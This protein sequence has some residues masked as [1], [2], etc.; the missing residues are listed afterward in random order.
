MYDKKIINE[1]NRLNFEDFLWI[2][3]IAIG[4]ITIYGN[5][6]QKMYIKTKD[7]YFNKK[8]NDI[9]EIALT[10]SLLI[11]IY[12]FTRNYKAYNNSSK[13]EKNLYEI[14]L[15]GSSLF[16]IGILCLLYFQEKQTSFVGSPA[17]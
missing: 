1:L 10:T 3:F 13:E 8:S 11:Y 12:F 16:I 5:Y 14:K 6:N 7:D 9:F 4:I 15:V 2:I 17:P